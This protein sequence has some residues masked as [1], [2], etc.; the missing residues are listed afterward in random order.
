MELEIEKEEQTRAFE[1]L[2]QARQKEREE[3][4]EELKTVKTQGYEYAEQVKNE[5]AIR[6]EKQ[7][8]MLESLLEDKKSMQA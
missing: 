3:F 4:K 7:V 6:I 5:M 2:K 1:M 8:E